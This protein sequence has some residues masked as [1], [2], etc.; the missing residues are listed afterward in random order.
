MV[1]MRLILLF[2]FI[3]HFSFGQVLDFIELKAHVL[4]N[5]VV[6]VW[7]VN[8]GSS[9]QNIELQH[10]TNGSDFKTY[11]VYSGIC[12]DP[13]FETTYERTHSSP[14]SGQRNYYR[15]KINQG[16]TKTVDVIVPNLGEMIILPHPVTNTSEIIFE[17][18]D[19]SYQL[20]VF[21]LMGE[22]VFQRP[23]TGNDRIYISKND[24]RQG[25]YIIVLTDGNRYYT[26]R[27]IVQ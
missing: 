25:S 1:T 15:L 18:V 13:E 17:G 14:I 2:L 6:L 4:K 23:I 3:S 19:D 16:H 24:I 21:N 5:Q 20:N 22:L 10:S 8:A 27:L 9:C 11:D 7:R 26:E 12:G